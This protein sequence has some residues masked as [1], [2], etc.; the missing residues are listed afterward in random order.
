MIDIDNVNF[1]YPG[2]R[3]RVFEG[4]SLHLVPGHIYG[5]FGK[6]GIGKSTLFRMIC[7]ANPI[8]SGKIRVL[9]ETPIDR[10]P[11][12]L[13]QLAL[14]PEDMDMPNIDLF[15]YA[16]R[17]GAF[18]PNYS[19]QDLCRYVDMFEIPKDQRI[20]SMSL[21]QR[22][23]AMIAYAFALNTKILLMDEPTNGLDITSKR[24]FR[25]MLDELPRFD[26]AIMI[27]THQVRDLEQLIDAVV[28]VNNAGI[29]LNETVAAIA[30]RY[31]F[32][33]CDPNDLRHPPIYTERAGGVVVG[34]RPR[35]TTEPEQEIDLEL[36]FAAAVSGAFEQ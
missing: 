29:A 11:S 6:N 3:M 34:I 21:G 25:T 31:V 15:A 8:E 33:P 10:S 24:V 4:V 32:G 12:L 27:S 14:I 7:G 20:S 36:L 30:D 26:R 23:K 5:L 22:K 28:I 2:K 17:Y 13:S 1:R 19:H 16:R 9:G 18:Y 35:S